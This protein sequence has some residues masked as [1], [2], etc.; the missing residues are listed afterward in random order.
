[1]A[2]ARLLV[3]DDS[4]TTR[5]MES[6]VFEGAGYDVLLASDGAQAWAMVQTEPFDA[7]V[8]D[9]D[10]PNMDG[11]ELTARIKSDPK[12]AMLP[13]VLVTARE[14]PEDEE[15]GRQAGADAYVRKSNDPNELIETVARLLA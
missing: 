7:V 4:L 10:M 2:L 5:T 1:M 11:L 15:A 9:V 13:V 3:V 8:S 14:K 12:F 6:I